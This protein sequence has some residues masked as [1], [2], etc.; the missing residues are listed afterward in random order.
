[1]LWLLDSGE[2]RT[3]RWERSSKHLRPVPK[4]PFDKCRPRE[5]IMVGDSEGETTRRPNILRM[6]VHN[7][8]RRPRLCSCFSLGITSYG[9]CGPTSYMVKQ[10]E[11]TTRLTII[12]EYCP[13]CHT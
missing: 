12:S 4:A 13:H 10:C 9:H 1:M 8:G 7:L 2:T 5:G 3:E 11:T 6:A